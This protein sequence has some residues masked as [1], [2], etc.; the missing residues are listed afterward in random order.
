[1]SAEMSFPGGTMRAISLSYRLCRCGAGG[2][3]GDGRLCADVSD[4][5]QD[6]RM[7]KTEEETGLRGK[8]SA[9][10]TTLRTCSA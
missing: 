1:M 9:T 2:S 5:V 10:E 6:M 8:S 3:A 4:L 7:G